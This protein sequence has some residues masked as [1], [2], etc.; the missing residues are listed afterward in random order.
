M[1]RW[2]IRFTAMLV[3]AGMAVGLLAVYGNQRF[4]GPGPLTR[5]RDIVIPKGAGLDLIAQTLVENGVIDNAL[6]FKI[7]VR[8]T[9]MH[10]SLKAGEYAFPPG[11]SPRAAASLMARGE[12]VVRKVTIPEGLTS[13]QIIKLLNETEGLSG[14]LLTPPPE[15]SLLPE[16]YHFSRDDSREAVL[17]RMEKAMTQTVDLL[18]ENRQPGLPLN[19]K[20]EAVILA[21]VV[22][23]ETGIARERPRV[24][25]VFLNRLRQGIKL[26]SDPTVI[27]GLSKGL[28]VLDHVLT[29]A[30]LDNPHPYNTYVIDGLPPAPIANP[31]RA[32]LEAVLN[33]ADSDDLY[34]VADGTGGHAFAKTLTEHNRN[35]AKWR[36][37]ERDRKGGEGE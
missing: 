10:G 19:S 30:D 37:L 14:R 9:G 18:W 34:F 31:G 27:Y 3:L 36:K 35:V 5:P 2:V 7:G 1:K 13:L 33:P 23:R 29:R 12:V 11:I 21:S 17:G 26:Q 32:S 8:L 25:A 4:N 28:G 15:G 22:E 20:E 16:T 6:I 24:A